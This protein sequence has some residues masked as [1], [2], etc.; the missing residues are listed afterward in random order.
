[1]EK[2]M[3]KKWFIFTEIGPDAIPY[4]FDGTNLDIIDEEI[5]LCIVNQVYFKEKNR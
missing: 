3:F 2:I 1:M 4:I 5:D